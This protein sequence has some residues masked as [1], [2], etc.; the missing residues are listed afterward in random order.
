L[1]LLGPPSGCVTLVAHLWLVRAAFEM[2]AVAVPLCS[3][4]VCQ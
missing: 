1:G 4:M 2:E 3:C